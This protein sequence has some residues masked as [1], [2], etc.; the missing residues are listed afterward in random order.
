MSFAKL[1]SPVPEEFDQLLSFLAQS[2]LLINM[3][4]LEFFWKKLQSQ[5]SNP[6]QWAVEWKHCLF[7]TPTSPLTHDSYLL[8]VNHFVQEVGSTNLLCCKNASLT[9]IYFQQA[10][11]WHRCRTRAASSKRPRRQTQTPTL[12]LR[13]RARDPRRPWSW[14]LWSTGSN[15]TTSF[16]QIWWEAKTL[17]I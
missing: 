10:S 11:A 5:D 13:V 6:G 2:L 4:T 3:T 14:R 7:A 16:H 9:V 15:A 17:L 12:R 8:L 1:L